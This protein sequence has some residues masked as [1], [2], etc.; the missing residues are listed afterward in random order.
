MYSQQLRPTAPHQSWEEWQGKDAVSC[1]RCVCAVSLCNPNGR[2]LTSSLSVS[3]CEVGKTITG[4][5]FADWGQPTAVG[6]DP[7]DP[8]ACMFQAA[9]NCTSA[10]RTKAAIEALCVGKNK[11]VVATDGLNQPDPCSG[12]HKRVAVLA[13]GCR[14]V[15]VPTPKPTTT[16][17]SSTGGGTLSYCNS[18]HSGLDETTFIQNASSGPLPH[19]RWFG[20]YGNDEQFYWAG[21][22]T[23]VISASAYPVIDDD[24][25]GDI[26]T[27]PD[28]KNWCMEAVRGG[29]L[30]V[31]VA[32][33][34]GHRLAVALINRSPMAAMITAPWPK[35]GL[36]TSAKMSVR[37]VWDASGKG[38]HAGH[39]ATEV[40][41]KGAVLLVLTPTAKQAV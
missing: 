10:A 27:D 29:D 41:G 34:S 14:A 7:L 6:A 32:E 1:F 28:A 3:Q 37:D 36:A 2:D 24:S 18:R 33:L 25:V 23:Q 38:E 21:N 16:F 19:S 26:T 11:C 31:W 5:E 20:P 12:R 15:A 17:T 30:E 8:A 4:I 40:G 39:F 9:S 22:G 35:L 13:T